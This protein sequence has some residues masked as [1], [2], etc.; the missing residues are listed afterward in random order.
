MKNFGV[1]VEWQKVRKMG[2]ES[3]KREKMVW[4]KLGSEE[5]RLEKK[6]RL[7]DRKELITEALPWTARRN[8]WKMKKISKKR[9]RE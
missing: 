9:R 5:Q 8:K 1:L 7:G 3:D 2:R 6:K 4:V